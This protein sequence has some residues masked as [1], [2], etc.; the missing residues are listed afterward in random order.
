M[1]RLIS[2]FALNPNADDESASPAV[3]EASPPEILVK[4]KSVKRS[5]AVVLPSPVE[6]SD[7]A[8]AIPDTD[9]NGRMQHYGDD[10]FDP[11]TLGQHP[12][13]GICYNGV[14]WVNVLVGD[15]SFGQMLAT[16]STSKL[17][18]LDF[19]MSV[20]HPLPPREILYACMKCYFEKLN[21]DIRL[22]RQDKVM[23]AIEAYLAGT[24]HLG[25]GWYAAINIILAHAIRNEPEFKNLKNDCDKYLYNTIS[26]IP[27]II[28][29]PPEELCIGALLSSVLYFMFSF[30]NQAA[31]SILAMAVQQMMISGYG[32]K[33]HGLTDVE[34]LHRRRLFWHGYILDNDLA[35]RL[36]KPAIFNENQNIDLPDEHP[37]DG[38]GIFNLGNG[39]FNFLREHVKLAKIQTQIYSKLHSDKVAN[40]S[41]EQLFTSISDLDEQLHTWKENIPEML[42]PQTPLDQFGFD[43]LIFVTVLHYTYFQLT[44]AIHSVVFAGFA[45]HNSNDRDTRIFPSVALCVAAARASISLLNYHDDSHPFTLYLV[46]H[47]AWSVDIL[48]MNIL[49]NKGSPRVLKDLKML[50]KIVSFYEAYDPD[51]ETSAAYQITKVLYIIASKAVSKAQGKSIEFTELLQAPVTGSS[52]LVSDEYTSNPGTAIIDQGYF[53]PMNSFNNGMNNGMNNVP[54]LESEWMMPLGF[55]PEYWQDPWA[56]VFQDPDISDLKLN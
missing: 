39:S 32:T 37:P 48:F 22:F 52:S 38:H 20:R 44:I 40:Q 10:R 50:E 45:A 16:L 42:R 28:L 30:E 49:Q 55:Q 27:N 46:N 17:R 53:P 8:W 13:T 54:F 12:D 43:R 36:G 15:E 24:P 7:F 3:S 11:P 35:L 2:D 6:E 26:V 9:M 23:D 4:E 5:P 29:Q 41:S 47:V 14:E 33:I 31:I 21:Q 34:I 56:N 1:E 19:D 18:H 25:Y 51:R